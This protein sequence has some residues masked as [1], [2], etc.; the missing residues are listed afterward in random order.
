[1]EQLLEEVVKYFLEVDLEL[2]FD[3]CPGKIDQVMVGEEVAADPDRVGKI[4]DNISIEDCHH[5]S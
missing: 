4:K 2:L 5:L 3:F 1:M